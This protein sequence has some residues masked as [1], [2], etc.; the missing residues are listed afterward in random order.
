MAHGFLHGVYHIINLTHPVKIC[1]VPMVVVVLV[2]PLHSACSTESSLPCVTAPPRALPSQLPQ[3]LLTLQ[4]LTVA[5]MSY[6]H[7]QV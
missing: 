6:Q 4:S 5:K 2:E 1:P 3:L 7:S